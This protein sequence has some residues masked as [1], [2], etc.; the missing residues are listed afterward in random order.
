MALRLVKPAKFVWGLAMG[1]PAFLAFI[2]LCVFG[3]GINSGVLSPV[4][5][6]RYSCESKAGI[7]EGSG[8]QTEVSV[9]FKRPIYS[10]LPLIHPSMFYS[11]DLQTLPGWS[12]FS[13]Q[14]S[15]NGPTAITSLYDRDPHIAKAISYRHRFVSGDPYT[16]TLVLSGPQ[17]LE[18]ECPFS[19]S[20]H[21]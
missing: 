9:N 6:P 8:L 10:L 12:I 21:Y 1:A 14:A 5:K 20:L 13:V 2:D 11:V 3:V 16:V 4:L 19:F 17:V 15:T 18:D 7:R